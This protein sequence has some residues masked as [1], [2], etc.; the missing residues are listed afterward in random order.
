MRIAKKIVASLKLDQTLFNIEF[1]YNSQK[2]SIHIIEINPRMSTQFSDLYE[3]VDGLNNY[4]LF[5]DLLTGR[6]PITKKK[7]TP[8][9]VASSFPLRF[10]ENKK[11]ISVPSNDDIAALHKQLPDARIEVLAQPGT[12]LADIQ[13]DGKS[14]CYLRS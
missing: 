7:K 11:V 10:F 2:N 14:F 13:Q 12:T 5:L 3:K 9:N 6:K 1:M 8:Y 4:Q